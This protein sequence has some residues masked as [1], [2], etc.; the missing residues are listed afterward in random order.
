MD[1]EFDPMIASVLL[2]GLATEA[3][4]DQEWSTLLQTLRDSDSE[5]DLKAVAARIDGIIR[6]SR[7]PTPE[8]P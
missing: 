7:L 5:P 4:V 1:D 3:P 6:C 8:R 2:S